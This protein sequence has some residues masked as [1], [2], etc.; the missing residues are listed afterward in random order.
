[1]STMK[2][3]I[4][5]H[6]FFF[7][8][9]FM[10]FAQS[11]EG[12]PNVEK[13]GGIF[14]TEAQ[15]DE[16]DAVTPNRSDLIKPGKR[17]RP[18]FTKELKIAAQTQN[19]IRP[20]YYVMEGYVDLSYQGFRLQADRAEYDAKTKDL[21]ATGNV[22]LDQADQHLTGDRLELNLE[23]KKGSMYNARGFVPPQ[24]FFW[25]ERLDKIDEEEYVLHKGVF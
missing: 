21:I 24:I 7:I 2:K 10:V 6:L 11:Q 25:G 22:V 13:T 3:R 23:T 17:T 16:P 4:L 5:F 14:P 9:P 15:A 19:E 18:T 12:P 20:N 1:M 8:F